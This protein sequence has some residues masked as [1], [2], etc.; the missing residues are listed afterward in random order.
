MKILTYYLFSLTLIS[1]TEMKDFSSITDDDNITVCLLSAEVYNEASQIAA[2]EY[3]ERREII[4]KLDLKGEQRATFFKEFLEDSNYEPLSR[5]CKFEP[6]Y[7][8]V[9]NKK[10][11]ALLDVEYCPTLQYVNG[12]K[13]KYVGIT[14]ENNLKKLLETNL[15]KL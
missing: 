15:K 7:A 3:L 4:S 13:S 6:V 5:K 12:K 1:C 14:A 10:L 9:V 11:F 2:K 8:V